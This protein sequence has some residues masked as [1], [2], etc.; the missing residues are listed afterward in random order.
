MAFRA[1]AVCCFAALSCGRPPELECVPEALP[2]FELPVDG[3]VSSPALAETSAGMVAAWN[4][5]GA[6]GG[7]ESRYTVIPEDPTGPPVRLRNAAWELP[8]LTQPNIVA[9]PS[10]GFALFWLSADGG[11]GAAQFWARV[12]DSPGRPRGAAVM[13]GDVVPDLPMAP[14]AYWAGSAVQAAWPKGAVSIAPETTWAIAVGLDPQFLSR[15]ATDLPVNELRGATYLRLTQRQTE[16]GPWL[17]YVNPAGVNRALLTRARTLMSVQSLT[18]SFDGSGALTAVAAI[19]TDRRGIVAALRGG[20]VQTLVESLEDDGDWTSLPG[21]A[22]DGVQDLALVE[23]AE[24]TW[25][26]VEKTDE[27][28]LA[29][30]FTIEG[31]VGQVLELGAG[32]RVAAIQSPRGVLAV[33][34]A[35]GRVVGSRLTCGNR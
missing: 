32:R 24:A 19:Q 1:L 29:Y 13:I 22:I 12:F 18:D 10:G 7:L 34:N 17:Y 9:L 15:V 26:L 14:P 8:F 3:E 11:P 21:L 33:W 6:D 25:L 16:S 35:M 28:L 30:P 27:S 31:A 5:R 20:R 2:A 4:E 23:G